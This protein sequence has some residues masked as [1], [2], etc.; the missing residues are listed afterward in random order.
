MVSAVFDLRTLF[1]RQMKTCPYVVYLPT[2]LLHLG[3]ND[4]VRQT[5]ERI[6]HL[7]VQEVS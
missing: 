2:M 7:F 4:K 6:Y 5:K 3:T 1:L